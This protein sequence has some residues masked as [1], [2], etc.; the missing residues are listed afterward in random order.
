M[1][2]AKRVTFNREVYEVLKTQYYGKFGGRPSAS[3]PRDSIDH[4]VDRSRYSRHPPELTLEGTKDAWESYVVQVWHS[5]REPDRVV[6]LVGCNA[7]LNVDVKQS[8]IIVVRGG[9]REGPGRRRH[10]T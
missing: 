5:R 6:A 4:I 1:C 3:H 7:C 8:R 9:R 10:I 2:E